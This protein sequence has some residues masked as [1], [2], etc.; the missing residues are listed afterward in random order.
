LID[1]VA[2]ILERAGLEI[3]QASHAVFG[4]TST[5]PT[6]VR[7]FRSAIERLGRTGDLVSKTRESLV[8][9]ARLLM[10]LS[11]ANTGA[12]SA[13]EARPHLKSA[14]RD[15]NQLSDHASFLS[16]K[17]AFLFDATMG[18]ISIEQNN[19]IKLFSVVAVTL[20]PPTL[21]ASVYG[22]NFDHMPELH[23][24]WAYPLVL[25]AMVASA[26]LPYVYFRRKGWL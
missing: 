9:I 4:H 26:I 5:S 24:A 22:M 8:T 18:L 23:F 16:S 10:F 7:D 3:D 13:K 2:D 14:L 19:I 11:S 1:R 6:R 15:A 25:I 20:M 21:I 12:K 17:I